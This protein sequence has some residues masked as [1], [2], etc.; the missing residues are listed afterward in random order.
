MNRKQLARHRR[1][2]L[3]RL[4]FGRAGL[5]DDVGQREH[6]MPAVEEHV[7]LIARAHH[8]GRQRMFAEADRQRGAGARGGGHRQRCASAIV[9]E[10]VAVARI[11][12]FDVV[13]AVLRVQRERTP[14]GSVQAPAVR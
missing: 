10:H 7:H 8:V 2:Q 4:R 11:L 5:R 6:A 3:P 13:R 14:V 1:G 9:V 12:E